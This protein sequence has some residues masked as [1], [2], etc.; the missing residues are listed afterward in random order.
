MTQGSFDT[1]V[2]PFRSASSIACL[3]LAMVVYISPDI[4]RAYLVYILSFT[5]KS[6]SFRV[7]EAYIR[8]LFLELVVQAQ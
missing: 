7:D 2:T 5:Y 1:S 8:L 6:I 3:R 4:T